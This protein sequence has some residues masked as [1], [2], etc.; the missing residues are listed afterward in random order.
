MKSGSRNPEA[1]AMNR[2][3]HHDYVVLQKIEAGIELCGSEVKSVRDGKVNLS[4]GFAVVENGELLL[5]DVHIPPYEH[6]GRYNHEATRPRRV[7][8]R[9]HEIRSLDEK[10]SQMG[11]TIVPLRLYPKRRWIKVELGLCKGRKM[12]D[13]R[14]VLRRRTDER[15][16]A[17]AISA[18]RRGN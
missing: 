13:K 3:A 8:L 1:F 2:K 18:A 9:A 15:E 16:I 4:A 10:V 17:R 6:G 5:R 7:L 11:F 12:G 14:E